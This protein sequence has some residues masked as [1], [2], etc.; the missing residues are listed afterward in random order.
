MLYYCCTNKG[1]RLNE[2]INYYE[3][4]K[5]DEEKE[6]LL[7]AIF[8][9]DELIMLSNRWKVLKQLYQDTPQRT[10]KEQ[11]GVSITTVTKG[12][13]VLKYGSGIVQI[14]L[15]REKHKNK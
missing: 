14:L 6:K 7:E 10:V 4:T 9:P 8:T 2:F 3:L 1:I 13:R 5:T 15:E 12:S 11:L